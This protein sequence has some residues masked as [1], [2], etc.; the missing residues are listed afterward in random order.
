MSASLCRIDTYGPVGCVS[1]REL[2]ILC[3]GTLLQTAEIA[4]RKSSIAFTPS[5]FSSIELVTSPQLMVDSPAC[6]VPP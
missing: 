3:H 1:L 6:L 4:G 5:P 2:C